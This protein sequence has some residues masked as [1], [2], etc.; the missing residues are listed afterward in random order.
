MRRLLTLIAALLVALEI[1]VVAEPLRVT[2]V[3]LD[4]AVDEGVV[5]LIRRATTEA[6]GG[7][8]VLEIDSYGGYLQSADRAVAEILSCNCR[9]VAWIP[10]GGKAA[11]AATLIALAADKL[12]VAPG[13]VLGALRPTPS[14]EKTME[15]V[16]SRLLSL[17]ERKRVPNS[18]VIARSMVYEARAYSYEEALRLRLADGSAGSLAELLEEEGLSGATVERLPSDTLREIYSLIFNPLLAILFLLLGA[19]L[20]SLEFHVT[21]FQGWGAAGAALVLLALYTF[22]LLGLG[23]ATLL[24][25]LLGLALILVELLQPGVQI[26]GL[27]G[28]VVI[29][30]AMLL[31][32]FNNP[33]A[34]SGVAAPILTG[35][36]L[37]T[38]LVAVIVA[39]GAEVIR[40]PA[41]SLEGTLIGKTGIARTPVSPRGGVVL[42]E[43]ELWSAVSEDEI[44]AGSRVVVVEVDGL[45][46]RV[47]RAD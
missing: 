11:S 10:P 23:L 26:F 35:L 8:I 20:I 36:A 25:A 14:D 24:L 40:A 30:L 7:V 41:P 5:Y 19:L 9:V 47:K 4:G 22:N 37:L 38:G 15:Y 17:L 13:A 44:P 27:A 28:V 34:L 2:V 16:Y 6:E 43:S 32:Y 39:K 31:E 21:G 46:L 29:L 18:T 3:R 1:L 42:V 12:Y 33:F 45:T